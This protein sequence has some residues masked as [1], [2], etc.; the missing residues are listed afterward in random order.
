MNCPNCGSQFPDGTSFCPYC[1]MQFNHNQSNYNQA[2]QNTAFTPEQ[3]GYNG[4]NINPYQQI[5]YNHSNNNTYNQMPGNNYNN[6]P[7]IS[8]G[9]KIPTAAIISIIAVIIIALGVGVFFIVKAIKDNKDTNNES[10]YSA[11]SYE[12]ESVNDITTVSTTEEY[13]FETTTEYINPTTEAHNSETTEAVYSDDSTSSVAGTYV[14]DSISFT[15]SGESM[16]YSSS[17]MGINS[18]DMQIVVGNNGDVILISEGQQGTGNISFKGDTVE[19][20]DSAVTIRGTYDDAQKT[21][22]I[23]FSEFLNYISSDDLSSEDQETLEMIETFDEM[24]VIFKK[25]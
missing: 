25:K 13:N 10:D 2:A 19:L 7:S 1:G 16:T 12:D 20:S 24:S 21:I 17:D 9:K 18:D 6:M 22:T 23:P 15:Y 8:S 14:L 3:S 4:N 11:K 5:P